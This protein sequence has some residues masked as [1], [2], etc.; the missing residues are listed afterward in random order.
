[1]PRAFRSTHDVINH[2]LFL[3]AQNAGASFN[4]GTTLYTNGDVFGF[5]CDLSNRLLWLSRN[6]TFLN[7]NPTTP[8]GGIGWG[9]SS[10]AVMYPAFFAN[11]NTAGTASATINSGSSAFM[12]TLPASYAAWGGSD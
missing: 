9:S 10:G 1:M 5:A 8:T 7:G 4:L 11:I 6:G 12:G 2:E 3:W